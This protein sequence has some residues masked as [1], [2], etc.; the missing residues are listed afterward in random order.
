METKVDIVEDIV[1]DID[2]NI[3]DNLLSYHVYM[4][5]MS[6]KEKKEYIKEII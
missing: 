2:V 1:G 6:N 5:N 4:N 3:Y